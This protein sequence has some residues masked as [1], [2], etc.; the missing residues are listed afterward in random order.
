ME[1][2]VQRDS[3][4]RA[5]RAQ[6]KK[7]GVED[8]PLPLS[9][10]DADLAEAVALS[11]K[12]LGLNLV[13][14][15][16]FV[17][18]EAEL[19][20]EQQGLTVPDAVDFPF[21]DEEDE[22][23][24]VATPMVQA[25]VV[26]AKNRFQKGEAKAEAG[27]SAGVSSSK[28]EALSKSG[29]QGTSWLEAAKKKKQKAQTAG[30]VA[31]AA[32]SEATV[33]GE[34]QEYGIISEQNKME[35]AG[36]NRVARGQLRTQKQEQMASVAVSEPAPAATKEVKGEVWQNWGA[37]LAAN[38]KVAAEQEDESRKMKFMQAKRRHANVTDQDRKAWEEH[39]VQNPGV[40]EVPVFQGDVPFFQRLA[41]SNVVRAA[42]AAAAPA[43]AP[44]A[45][46]EEGRPWF[47]EIGWPRPEAAAAAAPAAAP[48]EATAAAAAAAPAAAPA[49]ATAAAAAAAPAAALEQAVV[50]CSTTMWTGTVEERC[51]RTSLDGKMTKDDC[52]DFS[53]YFFCTWCHAAREQGW[54]AA[55]ANYGINEDDM[56]IADSQGEE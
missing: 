33:A 38:P 19:S 11:C 6:S 25:A 47:S 53:G 45:A 7:G 24:V 39:G 46:A 20:A 52:D 27:A 3:N 34:T 15:G 12:E 56:I 5:Q 23:A 50:R 2:K 37:Y 43:A 48:A 54:D 42:G 36:L 1:D 22:D 18:Q 4:A 28:Q 44:A 26:R 9:K 35:D 49:E 10:F 32:T 41:A 51:E 21:S 30:K 55:V 8:P 14:E 31:G 16:L 40:V 13:E 29:K 17:P